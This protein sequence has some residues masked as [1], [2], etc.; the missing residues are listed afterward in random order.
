MARTPDEP[1]GAF[2]RYESR[3]RPYVELNQAL[4]DP[5]REGPVPDDMMERAKRGIVLDDL[6]ELAP[7]P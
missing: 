1:S 7:R 2:Q 5:T 3:M 6:K 4:A